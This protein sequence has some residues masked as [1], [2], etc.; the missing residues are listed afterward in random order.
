PQ[1]QAQAGP[2]PGGGQGARADRAGKRGEQGLL[3]LYHSDELGFAM[4]LPICSSWSPVGQR[5]LVRYEAPQGRR[6]NV[7]GAYCSHGEETAAFAAAGITLFFLPSYSPELSKIEPIWHTVK[8]HEMTQ[9][10]HEV[11]GALLRAVEEA[12][13]RKAS[14]LLAAVSKTAQL[15]RA[16]A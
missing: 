15:F 14:D 7:I 10:S 3:D 1:R 6:V 13:A 9:R 16:A 5:L 12:L 11:L 2:R 4:T 8:H